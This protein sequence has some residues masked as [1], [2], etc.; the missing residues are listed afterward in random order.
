[1]SRGVKRQMISTY[2]ASPNEQDGL[3]D[4]CDNSKPIIY[5]ILVLQLQ[6]L[7]GRSLNQSRRLKQMKRKIGHN[8]DT[9]SHLH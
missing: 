3:N 8:G 5:L 4:T 1:M 9:G 2:V 7:K 6:P